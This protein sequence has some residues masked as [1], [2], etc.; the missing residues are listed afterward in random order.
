VN[1]AKHT[2]D[3]DAC[4]SRRDGLRAM[5]RSFFACRAGSN[6]VEFAILSPVIFLLFFGI[7]HFGMMIATAHSITQIAADSAR[8]A[9]TGR[10]PDERRQLVSDHL[11][12]LGGAY[13]TSPR[14][15]LAFEVTEKHGELR[16]TISQDVSSIPPVPMMDAIYEEPKRL[17]RTSMVMLP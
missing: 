6:A 1:T 2:N 12:A 8:Y 10:T 11:D 4:G 16:V 14:S 15:L 7:V 13:S 5:R 3:E 17:S 9:M